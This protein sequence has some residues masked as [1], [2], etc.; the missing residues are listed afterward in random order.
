MGTLGRNIYEGPGFSNI[1]LGLAKH[2]RITERITTTF[3]FE[4]FN[5]LNRTNFDLPTATLNSGNFMKITTAADP[6]IL[7]FALR[8]T[9]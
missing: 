2:F 8:T 1:D 3:R 4:A 6:R 5:S 7:Q 9:W